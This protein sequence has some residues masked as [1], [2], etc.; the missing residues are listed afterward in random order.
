M[1]LNNRGITIIKVAVDIG[2]SF[3]S[4]QAIFT[5]VL[6]M[7]PAAVKIVSKSLDFVPKPCR[8]DMTQKMLMMFN[9]ESVLSK[10]DLTGDE[11]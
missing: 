3:D 7:K 10:K 6:G 11:S 5:D 4:C 8:M 1:I 9:D 2:I